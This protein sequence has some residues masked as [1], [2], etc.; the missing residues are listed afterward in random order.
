MKTISSFT[1]TTILRQAHV[2]AAL[3]L[4]S[5]TAIAALEGLQSTGSE[6]LTFYENGVPKSLTHYRDGVLEGSV[7]NWHA[8]GQLQSITIYT[9]GKPDGLA[10]TW[11]SNGQRKSVTKYSQGII[12]ADWKWSFSSEVKDIDSASAQYLFGFSHTKDERTR[13]HSVGTTLDFFNTVADAEPGQADH[14]VYYLYREPISFLGVDLIAVTGEDFGYGY[15]ARAYP[16]ITLHLDTTL[17]ISSSINRISQFADL[18]QCAIDSLPYDS[19]TNYYGVMDDV[20]D[21]GANQI[22]RCNWEL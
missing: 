3:V 4:F 10:K 20:K 21:I 16:N 5:S 17:S 13:K 18:H 22:M 14:Q 19:I 12:K 6:V 8:N 7:M 1:K 11:F 9:N 2:V 15:G